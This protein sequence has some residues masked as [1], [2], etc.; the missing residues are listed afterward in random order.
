MATGLWNIGGVNLPDFGISEKLSSLTGGDSNGGLFGGLIQNNAATSQGGLQA[1]APYGLSPTQNQQQYIAQN[2]VV[3]SPSFSGPVNPNP[4]PTQQQQT[5][6]GGGWP[7]AAATDFAATGGVG[8]GGGATSSGADYSGFLSQLEEMWNNLGGQSQNLQNI[9]Q[10]QTAQQ[11]NT[12]DL[13]NTQG[14]DQF[15]QYQTKSLKGVGSTIS[16]AFK[17]GNNLL[18]SMGAGD[19]SAANQYAFALAKE[20]SKQR[21]AIMADV[22]QRMQGLKQTYDTATNNL[23]ANLSQQISSIAQWFSQQQQGLMG[24]KAEVAKQ[25]SDQ[26]YQMAVNAL[27]T[28][29]SQAAGM[30]NALNGWVANNATSIQQAQQQIQQ[31]VQANPI[32]TAMNLNPQATVASAAPA[33]FNN[34]NSSSNDKTKSLFNNNSFLS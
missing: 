17:A 25:K 14:Q 27:Q 28:V 2:P 9:A 21:G 29:Q 8:K 4:Q 12:L 11:Q 32:P 33:Y 34:A 31:N 24:Q 13:Q 15:Q 7:N 1:N 22:S 19:S 5:T 20:G 16:N 30:Q 26:A 3:S 10:Q 23:K 6:G 18:G